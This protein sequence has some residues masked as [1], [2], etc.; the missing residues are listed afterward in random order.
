MSHPCIVN[1]CGQPAKGRSNKC[2]AHRTALRRNGHPEQVILR[3]TEVDPYRTTIRR[4][5]RRSEGSEFW[6][7]LRARWERELRQ[8]AAVLSDEARGLAIS[9]HETDAA[10]ELVKLGQNVAFQELAVMALAVFV[11]QMERGSRFRDANAF[12]CQLVRRVRALDDLAYSKSWDHKRR[13]VRRGYKDF[14]PGATVV[15]AEHLVDAF[16]EGAFR[17]HEGQKV[18]PARVAA[19]SAV[20][21]EAV[22]GLP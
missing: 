19:E 21:A 9:T 17:L 20:L 6:K 13:K 7:V 3:I 8:A 22:K 15:L 18:G 14:P 10:R 11:M 16:W 5:W 12:R 1:G 4:S 2:G